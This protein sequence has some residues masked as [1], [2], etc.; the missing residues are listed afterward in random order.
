MVLNLRIPVIADLIQCYLGRKK[1]ALYEISGCK[2][3]A[4][5]GEVIENLNFNLIRRGFVTSLKRAADTE[6][7]IVFGEF[8]HLPLSELPRSK[9]LLLISA[10]KESREI[11]ARL[12]AD[13]WG[14]HP[15]YLFFNTYESLKTPPPLLLLPFT[16]LKEDK[17]N[18]ILQSNS[19]TSEA[20][21]K[22]CHFVA[23]Y[24][25]PGDEILCC[26][27][28]N[29]AP[30]VAYILR[31]LSRGKVRNHVDFTENSV[32]VITYLEG[33]IPLDT[34]NNFYRALRPSGRLFIQLNE[35]SERILKALK[36]K[37]LLES[38]WLQND[39]AYSFKEV[40]RSFLPASLSEKESL[41]AVFMLSPLCGDLAKE[42]CPFLDNVNNYSTPPA[43]L[44]NFARDYSR[45]WLIRALVEMAFRLRNTESLLELCDEVLKRFPSRS[46][47][48]G[49][50]L[51]V[52]GYNVINKGEKDRALLIERI[53]S[54]FS[55]KSSSPHDYRWEAS[56]LLIK[57]E[58]LRVDGKFR[59]ADEVFDAVTKIDASHFSPILYAKILVAYRAKATY[60]K[61]NNDYEGVRKALRGAFVTCQ[62]LLN[63]SDI[64]YLGDIDMPLT[65]TYLDLLDIVDQGMFAVE[66]LGNLE[67]CH[68]FGTPFMTYDLGSIR[69][70]STV[71][72]RS[73]L[74]QAEVRNLEVKELLRIA[75]ERLA[76]I[77]SLDKLFHELYS[78]AEERLSEINK[79]VRLA[80][81]RFNR[82]IELER[83]NRGLKEKFGNLLNIEEE[84]TLEQ[85]S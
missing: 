15:K 13:S 36:Q 42:M 30:D 75:D 64:E 71:Y 38:I 78:T 2:H 27:K 44:I 67:R 51:C 19:L 5:Y 54:F 4:L 35:K 39:S 20:L 16:S 66:Q 47:E 14:R 25:R 70:R 1:V 74:L 73:L 43:N 3:N 41:L 80:D 69:E 17:G 82:L 23:E 21:L 50:A 8:L 68:T 62:K 11:E 59:E 85:D 22:R 81:E 7:S 6:L 40:S 55:E 77:N 18:C 65:T 48:L 63:S 83:E 10:S 45:P 58:I 9:E 26:D 32:D 76:T 33:E 31:E 52:M 12:F 72:D 56:L 29:L 61:I 34:I 84:A 46:P 57:G 28:E 53:D 60:A 24:V 79:L 37:F 49:A